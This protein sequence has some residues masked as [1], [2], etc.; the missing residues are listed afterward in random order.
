MTIKDMKESLLQ[1]V[2]S[3][4]YLYIE[5]IN[6]NNLTIVLHIKYKQIIALSCTASA[7]LCNCHTEIKLE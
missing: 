2:T 7:N 5:N 1:L 3:I 4:Y 6:K